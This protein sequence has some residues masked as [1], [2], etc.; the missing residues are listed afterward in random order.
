MELKNGKAKFD[1]I[2]ESL[3]PST[4]L[5]RA[6]DPSSD[7]SPQEY[8]HSLILVKNKLFSIFYDCNEGAIK[9]HDASKKSSLIKLGEYV[10]DYLIELPFSEFQVYKAIAGKGGCINLSTQR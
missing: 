3:P 4:Y 5:I 10:K 7:S 2:I 6:L 9:I 1:K 8:S